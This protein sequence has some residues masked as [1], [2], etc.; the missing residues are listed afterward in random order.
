[1][2]RRYEIRNSLKHEI[3]A[4]GLTLADAAR[5]AGLSYACVSSVLNGRAGPSRRVMLAMADVLGAPAEVLF[6]Q[7]VAEGEQ[8]IHSRLARRS[9][10]DLRRHGSRKSASVGCAAGGET[11]AV[12][13]ASAEALA[14]H[15]MP[16]KNT[17]GQKPCRQ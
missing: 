10:T 4:R 15:L 14:H 12:A 1:M 13:C 5:A 16:E 7:E 17:A 6:P 2:A 9:R 3:S 11:S 8:P